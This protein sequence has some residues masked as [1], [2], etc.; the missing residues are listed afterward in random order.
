[1]INIFF[2]KDYEER[3]KGTTEILKYKKGDQAFIERQKAGELII[4]GIAEPFTAH[5]E[6]IDKFEKPERKKTKK[7]TAVSKRFQKRE[8]AVNE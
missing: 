7:E 5:M 8:K 6:R 4:D 1:M 2:L 3:K